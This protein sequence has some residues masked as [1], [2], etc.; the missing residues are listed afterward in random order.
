[1]SEVN[2]ESFGYK[3]EFKR[4]LSMRDL[5]IFGMIFMS[6]MSAMTLFGIMNVTSNGHSV[7]AFLFGFVAMLF[8]ALSYGEMV[9]AFPIAGSTYSYTQRGI[10][11][12]M[13]FIAGWGM[14]L[15]YFLIPMFLYVLSASYAHAFLPQ[16]PYWV[17]ILAYV[18]PVTFINIIGVE[19]AAKANT[20]MTVIMLFA[21]GAFIFSAIHYVLV[22][23]GLS[24]FS[25]K[26]I[27]NPA[28]FNFHSM[29]AGSAMAVLSYLGFDAITTLSEEVNESGKM[30]GKAIIIACLL[31]TVI[32]LAISYF[33]NLVFTDYSIIKNPD[34]VLYD[35][36]F[37]IGG[38]SLQIFLTLVIIVSGASTALAGQSAASRLLYGMG[39]DRLIPSKL[40]SYLHP[41]YNTPTFSILF[42][43]II[44]IIGALTIS[45]IT[46]SE[47]VTFGGLFGFIC[48]NLS[49]IN[50][51]FIKGNSKRVFLHIIMPILGIIVCTYILFSLSTVAKIVGFS[52]MFIGVIYVTIR[53]F[54]SS[55]FKELLK[56]EILEV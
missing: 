26:A 44:G 15:D 39:R 42:M 56:K 1:M 38:S 37:Q 54:L 7:L 18:I 5:V 43:G 55:D 32:Y 9:K 48:V 30:I 45:M 50:H 25:A 34:T 52:W 22:G 29:V 20:I 2:L 46:L 14:L 12:K 51:Y 19:V 35:I 11:P 10:N 36:A 16:I 24:L 23:H 4:T 21:V 6:P 40:F 27:Y 3:Q 49:V 47:M 53:S 13:G 41:K 33:G 8:T 31:Q 17:L 28:T